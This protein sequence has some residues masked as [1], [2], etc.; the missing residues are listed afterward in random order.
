MFNLQQV[1]GIVAAIVPILYQRYF[2]NCEFYYMYYASQ[3]VYVVA[4]SINLLAATRYNLYWGISDPLLYFFGGQLASILEMSIGGF[5]G[6]LIFA[7]IIPPGIESTLQSLSMSVFF[8]MFL[9]K[10]FVGIFINDTFFHMTS[11]D[12]SG[13]VSLRIVSLVT[14]ILPFFYLRFFIPKRAKVAALQQK[15]IDQQ[16]AKVS[17]DDDQNAINSENSAVTSSSKLDGSNDDY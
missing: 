4:D 10:S 5:A 14:S 9:M 1:L 11:A 15:F 3:T 6:L 7:K 17:D 12:M 16:K 8:F 2:A 13:Y